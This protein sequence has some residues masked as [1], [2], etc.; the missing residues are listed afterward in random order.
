VAWV[1]LAAMMGAGEVMAEPIGTV[2]QCLF[3]GPVYDVVWRPGTAQETVTLDLTYAQL[4]ARTS[5][6]QGQG[7]AVRQMHTRV[8]VCGKQAPDVRFDVHWRKENVAETWVYYY[9][10]N[11]FWARNLSL[12][13]QG[14]RLTM[15]DSF[16]VNGVLYYNALWRPGTYSQADVAGWAYA[17]FVAEAQSRSRNG[18]R[19]AVFDTVELADG[20]IRYNASWR[21]GSDWAVFQWTQADFNAKYSELR[22]SGWN[23][24][25]LSIFSGGSARRYNA[26]WRKTNLS[27]VKRAGLSPAELASQMASR[28]ASGW[29]VAALEAYW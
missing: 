14:W 26:S 28:Q 23:L 24:G 25:T 3:A 13:S 6:L 21:T 19:I 17:D 20:S 16:V 22:A 9:T 27:E 5:E 10:F 11:D 29:N 15:V 4:L 7:W 8:Y 12:R 2:Q 18:W 1:G